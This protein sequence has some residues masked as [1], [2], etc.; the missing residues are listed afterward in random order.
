[1]MSQNRQEEKDRLRSQND[2]KVNLKS[3]ILV[4]DM[5]QK[6]DKLIANQEKIF[7]KIEMM[8]KLNANK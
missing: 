8:E 7:K 4:E 2:Y 1:M 5:H 3:E 6:L